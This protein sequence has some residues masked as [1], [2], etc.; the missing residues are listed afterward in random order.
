MKGIV[1]SSVA[2]VMATLLAGSSLTAAPREHGNATVTEDWSSA[3]E[4][5]RLLDEIRGTASL[6]KV[7]TDTL[8]SY[9][10]GGLAWESHASRLNIARDHINDIGKKLQRLEEIRSSTA[11]WQRNAA[12][13]ITRSAASLAE[14]TEAAINHLNGNRLHLWAPV[15]VD[16]LKSMADH[17]AQVKKSVDVHLELADTMDKLEDLRTRAAKSGS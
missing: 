12:D 8:E 2:V 1:F 9:T 3:D 14:R 7:Q 5:S 10:R 17:A 15:Y 4:A 13:S 6:L 16:H 11:P